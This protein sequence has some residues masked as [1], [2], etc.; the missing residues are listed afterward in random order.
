LA[1]TGTGF[2]FGC[3]AAVAAAGNNAIR[4]S[5]VRIRYFSVIDAATKGRTT[6]VG[7][8]LQKPETSKRRGPGLGQG[9]RAA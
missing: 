4:R 6:H 8:L 2:F 1:V 5:S 7:P 3:S 9:L